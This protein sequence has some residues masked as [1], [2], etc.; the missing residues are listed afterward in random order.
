MLLAGNIVA[1]PASRLKLCE[2]DQTQGQSQIQGR[3]KIW[4]S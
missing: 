2:R 3:I 4:M 1:Y